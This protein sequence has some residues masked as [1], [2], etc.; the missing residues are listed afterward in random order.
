MSTPLEKQLISSF[1]EAWNESASPLLGRPSAL[2][3]LALR[4][5]SG[6]GM[7]SAL[8]VAGTW[9]SAFVVPSC[10]EALPGVMICLFKSDDSAVLDRLVK[11]KSSEGSNPGNRTLVMATL[12]ATAKH[13]AKALSISATFEG[14]VTHLDL[15]KDESRLAHI[16][17]DSAWVGTFSLTVGDDLSTQV[18]LLYASRG[19]VEPLADAKSAV[20]AANASVASPP[21]TTSTADPSKAATR[22]APNRRD[23]A[24]RNIERLLDVE[25]EVIV[26][27]GLTS[28]PLRDVVRMGTGTV[29]ELDRAVDEPVELL[30]NGRPLARGEVVVV[31]GFYGVRITEITGPTERALTLL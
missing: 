6:D 16:V 28:S 9:S 23:E 20:A 27:F 26:R 14:E 17:G 7:A 13:L 31:D 29:I 24:P 11:E 4:E 18:L 5:V 21:Q 3:L 22:R 10:G 25:M 30:I 8:A 19:S 15:A 2:T 1:A 12:N